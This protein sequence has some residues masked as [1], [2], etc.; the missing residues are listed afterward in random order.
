MGE[1]RRATGRQIMGML[2]ALASAG[3]VGG[4]GPDAVAGTPPIRDR[5]RRVHQGSYPV[6]VVP[7]T[8]PD[9][10]HSNSREKG[11]RLRQAARK[12][13]KDAKAKGIPVTDP[14][15]D[16]PDGAVVDGLER[17]GD[18]WHPTDKKE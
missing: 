15:L 6:S 5:P 12:A 7:Y 4:P 14:E 17:V 11:R 2:A 10:S 16:A 1:E 13:E 9:L 3:I 18:T 8:A